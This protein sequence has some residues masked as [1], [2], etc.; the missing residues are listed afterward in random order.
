MSDNRKNT[1]FELDKK[2]GSIIKVGWTGIPNVLL[3]EQGRLGLKALELNV[4]INLIRFWWIAENIPFPSPEK[5]SAEM[6][7]SERTVY[8]AI[9]SLEK[10]GFITRIQEEDKPTK[11]DLTN[12]IK[13]LEAIKEEIIE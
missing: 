3:K 7:V 12:L 8:R 5:I 13:K 4:L 2:W 6:G 10:N 11:Y 9:A 1:E